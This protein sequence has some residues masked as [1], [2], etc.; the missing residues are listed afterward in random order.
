MSGEDRAARLHL[1]KRILMGRIGSGQ[2]PVTLEDIAQLR[3]WA[4]TDEERAMPIEKLADAILRRER[5]GKNPLRPEDPGRR[6]N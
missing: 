6:R 2:P 3:F 4:E 5:K 1:A